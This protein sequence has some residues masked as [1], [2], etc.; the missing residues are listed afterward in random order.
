MI[1]LDFTSCLTRGTASVDTSLEREFRG[2]KGGEFRLETA[3]EGLPDGVTE[4]LGEARGLGSLEVAC[5]IG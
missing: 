1:E 3:G 2:V 4:C 5:Q